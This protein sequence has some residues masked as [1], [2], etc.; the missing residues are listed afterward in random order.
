MYILMWFSYI[1]TKWVRTQP[2][3]IILLKLQHFLNDDTIITST[4]QD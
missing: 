1:Y 3:N 2:S 4:K